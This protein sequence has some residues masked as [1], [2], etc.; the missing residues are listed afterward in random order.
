MHCSVI[1]HGMMSLSFQTAIQKD[2]AKQTLISILLIIHH[3]SLLT[4]KICL[5]KSV[6]V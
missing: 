2:K 1:E 3:L 5:G 6:L 4:T